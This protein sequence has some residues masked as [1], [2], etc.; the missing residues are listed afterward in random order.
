MNRRDFLAASAGTIAAASVSGTVALGGNKVDQTWDPDRP[1]VAVGKPLKVQPV[2]MYSVQTPREQSSWRS[3][4]RISTPEAAGEEASRISQ[5]LSKLAAG[6]TFPLEVLPLVKV[7][8]VGEA[9]KLHAKPYDVILLYPATGSA[10][11]LRA[12]FPQAKE[13]DVVIFVRHKSGPVYYWYE[14]LSTR[15]LKQNTPDEI[16]QNS[17][18]DHGG[19]TVDDVAV[20]DYAEVLW[21]LN[22]LFALQNFVGHRI[23]AMGG[24]QGKY[25]AKAPEVARRR[26]KIDIV[27]VSYDDFTKRMRALQNSRDAVAQAEKWTERYLALPKTVLSTQK[28]FITNAFLLYRV[29]K[30]WM[31]E[32]ES[33]A[34]T[35]QGCMGQ[36]IPIAETTACMTL[37]WLNDEGYLAFC[38]SDFVIMPPGI[39]LRYIAGAPVFMHN[40]TFPHKGVVTCAHCTAPRRMDGKRY[41]PTRI[42]THYES[43]Y[44][45]APK[46]DIPIGQQ[47]TFI[48]PEYATGR[49][50]SFTGIVKDNPF[51]EICR[52]QQDVEIQ[53]DW[54]RLLREVRDSHWMMVYGNHLQKIGYAAGKIGLDWVDLSS[55]GQA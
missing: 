51:Y 4:S 38:E 42:L 17:A 26:F 33:A 53:G 24:P 7:A 48:D 1:L 22:S 35:I 10:D 21:R 54:K 46:V 23:V 18:A 15:L 43:D 47:V 12:C 41:E 20:D 49:W 11:M 16:R 2:L 34:V 40:S 30:D 6:A 29:F 28:R 9:R 27:D 13:R 50:L 31:R 25:D 8:S 55:P 36:A 19:P 32:Y 45:A 39:F 5:E 44:G 37:S 3:W 52:S 14:A